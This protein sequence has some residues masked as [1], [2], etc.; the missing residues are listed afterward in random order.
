MDDYLH[1]MISVVEL[2]DNSFAGRNRGGTSACF[3]KWSKPRGQD[4]RGKWRKWSRQACRRVV[5][6]DRVGIP[7]QPVRFDSPRIPV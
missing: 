7:S 3:M 4:P 5:F 2:Q 6:A 1:L